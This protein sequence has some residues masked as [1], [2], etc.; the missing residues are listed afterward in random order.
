MPRLVGPI[1]VAVTM[2]AHPARAEVSIAPSLGARFALGVPLGKAD[3]AAS[4]DMSHS[5]PVAV[6][7]WLDAGLRLGE[8]VYVGSYFQYAYGITNNCDP[9]G[10]CSASILRL[11]LDGAYHFQPRGG[12]D[13]WVGLG[14]GYEWLN[15]SESAGGQQLDAQARGW[16]FLN[17][18]LGVDFASNKNFHLGPF[19]SLSLAQYGHESASGAFNG[20]ADITNTSVHEWLQF[21]V[22]GAFEM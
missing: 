16:E 3:G 18:Q 15:L 2:A 4:Q 7:L 22:R 17:V 12:V 9:G 13:P 11:G 10:S 20:S 21:G 8:N 6:P 19:L 14:F 1:V 5:V